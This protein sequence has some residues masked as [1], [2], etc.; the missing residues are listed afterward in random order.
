MDFIGSFWRTYDSY[1]D[2]Q[3]LEKCGISPKN[4]GMAI[5]GKKKRKKRK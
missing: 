1:R 2:M 5:H 4:Y 3:R